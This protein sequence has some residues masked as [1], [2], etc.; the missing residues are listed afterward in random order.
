MPVVPVCTYPLY[1][2]HYK[3]LLLTVACMKAVPYW[4]ILQKLWGSRLQLCVA[5][6]FDGKDPH[7]Q[8]K[9]LCRYFC[10]SA[11]VRGDEDI[12]DGYTS[13]NIRFFRTPAL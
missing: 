11:V 2:D 6:S 12:S 3:A 9:Y 7:M 10:I 8:N 1:E 5:T 13:S 4:Q